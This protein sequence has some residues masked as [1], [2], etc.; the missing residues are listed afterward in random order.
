MFDIP[1]IYGKRVVEGEGEEARTFCALYIYVNQ[2]EI[3]C[4]RR[5]QHD[6]CA[7][8]N[9][10]RRKMRWPLLHGYYA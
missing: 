9:E 5:T 2:S 1:H 10:N 4:K 6:S 3:V 7:S 8:I